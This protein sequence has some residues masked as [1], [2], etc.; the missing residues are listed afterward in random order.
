M[1]CNAPQPPDPNTFEKTDEKQ[2]EGWRNRIELK[3]L[4]C[5]TVAENQ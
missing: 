3:P 4:V 2:T 5:C 1:I